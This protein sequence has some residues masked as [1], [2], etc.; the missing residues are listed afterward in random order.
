[1]EQRIDGVRVKERKKQIEINQPLPS[2]P[3]PFRQEQEDNG[4]TGTIRQID[5]SLLAKYRVATPA[6]IDVTNADLCVFHQGRPLLR[7]AYLSFPFQ[8]YHS[9]KDAPV[10]AC[11]C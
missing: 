1:M 6:A 7:L 5:G 2:S 4:Q 3:L 9:S 11:P 10:L 8:V